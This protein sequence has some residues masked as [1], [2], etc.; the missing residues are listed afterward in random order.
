LLD[1]LDVLPAD[2]CGAWPVSGW[3]GVITEPANI[4]RLNGIIERWEENGSKPLKAAAAASRKVKA[5]GS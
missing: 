3:N 5:R 1:L 2:R 4:T